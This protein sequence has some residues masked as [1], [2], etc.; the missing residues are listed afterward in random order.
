[1]LHRPI[2]TAGVHGN[3]TCLAD[4]QWGQFTEN[5]GFT[6]NRRKIPIRHEGSLPDKIAAVGDVQHGEHVI[7][8][9]GFRLGILFGRKRQ[10]ASSVRFEPDGLQGDRDLDAEHVA[11]LAAL[12]LPFRAERND[13]ERSVVRR[14]RVSGSSRETGVFG[15]LT[16]LIASAPA[17][18]SAHRKTSCRVW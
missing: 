11:L 10:V 7:E 3:L 15:R 9:K 4:G 18:T 2:E 12:N 6:G 16:S 1:V 8:R 13:L 17:T 14:H 5:E